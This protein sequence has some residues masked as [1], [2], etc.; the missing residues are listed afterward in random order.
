MGWTEGWGRLV[1]SLGETGGKM[2][3]LL[4]P[5]PASPG[6]WTIPGGLDG[7]QAGGWIFSAKQVS[8]TGSYPTGV[9]GDS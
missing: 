7:C 6:S 3:M 4:E 1:Q 8:H 9:E 5:L 2:L